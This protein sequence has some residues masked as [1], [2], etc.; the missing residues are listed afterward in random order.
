[1][2]VVITLIASVFVFGLIIFVHE[3]GH[4][5]AARI[6]GIKVN[7]FAIGMGPTIIKWKRKDTKYSI[8]LFPI[9]G[10]CSMEGEDEESEEEGSFGK[11]PVS[12][13]ILVVL[14]GAIMNLLLGFIVIVCLTAAKQPGDS[15]NLIRT[16]TI[17]GFNEGAVT[18]ASGMMAGDTIL[19]VNGRNMYTFNDV[20]YE[21]ARV[22]G[23]FTD[24][25]VE[26]DGSRVTLPS[27]E[28]DITPG[29]DGVNIINPD[30]TILGVEKT[31][32][33]VLKESCLWTVSITRLVFVSF[34]D[35]VTGNVAINQLSGPVGI[36][37][38]IGQAASVDF[39][40]LFYI[41]AIITINLGVMNV[42]PLPALDGGRFVILLIEAVTKKRLNPKYEGIIHAVGFVLLILLMLFVTYNDITKL[43]R[44]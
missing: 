35:L 36:I 15:K 6:G 42:L 37:E 38:V 26:R 17:L 16:R 34:V 9:G 21:L 13:R 4:F 43:F 7:E 41:L 44:R 28:F 18:E 25:I 39:Y 32:G 27:V 33:S 31:F 8:R 12:N 11:A 1:M 20:I 19:A 14:A 10:F 3:F 29:E 5:I 2:T 22:K 23:R 24:V 30:F 40:S